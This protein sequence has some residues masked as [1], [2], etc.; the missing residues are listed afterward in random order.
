M[1]TDHDS[2]IIFGGDM[3]VTFDILL[4]ADGGNPSQ[5]NYSKSVRILAT[6]T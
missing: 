1:D 6:I 4:E 5:D 2:K 3:N